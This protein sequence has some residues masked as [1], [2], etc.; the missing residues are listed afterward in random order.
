MSVERFRLPSRLERAH[1]R[2]RVARHEVGRDG[3]DAGPADR[4]DRQREGVVAGEQREPPLR[5][6]EDPA[7]LLQ[8]AARLLDRHDVLDGGQLRE[9]LGLD[10]DRRAR[11][12]VVNHDGQVHR[13][14]HRLEVE[15]EPPLGRLVVV[16]RNEQRRVGPDHLGMAREADRLPG[17][18]GSGAGDDGDAAPRR[19][20]RKLDDP[21]VLLMGERGRLARRAARHES[22]RAALNVQVDEPR[23]CGLIDLAIAKRRHE[24]HHGAAKLH[25]PT[26][27]RSRRPRKFR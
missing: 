12:D 11:T 7:H 23:E 9:R 19:L 17:V 1:Q 5:G 3:N 8:V 20:D 25:H 15:V 18:V 21:V 24:R 6:L 2:R 22:A 4:Q 27:W 14:R 13:L 16:G 26:T 10:V